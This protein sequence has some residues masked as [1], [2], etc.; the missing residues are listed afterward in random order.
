MQL[1]KIVPLHSSL[2]NNSE[3][4]SQK[5]KDILL[6][7]YVLNSVDTIMLLVGYVHV[8][9]CEWNTSGETQ[10][11]LVTVAFERGAGV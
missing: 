6:T 5:K 11:N 4:L 9:V 8:L 7:F 3:T 10:K 1:A 2:G